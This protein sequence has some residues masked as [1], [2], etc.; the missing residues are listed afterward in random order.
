MRTH[1]LALVRDFCLSE[2]LKLRRYLLDRLRCELDLSPGE[3]ELEVAELVVGAWIRLVEI[4]HYDPAAEDVTVEAAVMG[5]PRLL[6]GAPASTGA[7]DGLQPAEM[8]PDD[9]RGLVEGDRIGGLKSAL[10]AG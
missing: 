3:A 7:D 4:S 1:V 6:A 9:Q 8:H 2:R 10:R 5:L